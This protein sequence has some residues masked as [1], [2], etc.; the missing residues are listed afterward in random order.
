MKKITGSYEM[1]ADK[2]VLIDGTEIADANFVMCQGT[3]IAV[4][5]DDAELPTLYPLPRVARMDG[6]MELRP[7][8]RAGSSRAVWI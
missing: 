4:L 6:V 5:S 7:E 1:H 2:I 8:P 3:F